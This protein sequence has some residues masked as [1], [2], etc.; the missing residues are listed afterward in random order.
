MCKIC[1][2]RVSRWPLYQGQRSNG[3]QSHVTCVGTPSGHRDQDLSPVVN[4]CSSGGQS[5]A[6][7]TMLTTHI[8]THPEPISYNPSQTC[9]AGKTKLTSNLPCWV[10]F[11]WYIHE[12]RVHHLFDKRFQL[13]V[14]VT[15]AIHLKTECHDLAGQAIA[16][17]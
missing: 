9:S 17:E 10:H 6:G 11:I 7:L 8:H 13:T 5:T 2:R 15:W 12:F 4:V 3:G 14:E 16:S 1:T